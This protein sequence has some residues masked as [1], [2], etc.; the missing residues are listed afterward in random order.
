MYNNMLNCLPV[1]IFPTLHCMFT[2]LS[3]ACSFSPKNGDTFSVDFSNSYNLYANLRAHC[4][5]NTLDEIKGM[6]MHDVG[7]ACFERSLHRSA[8]ALENHY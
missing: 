2:I 6:R 7:H 8:T 1:Y 3:V 4:Q 5:H